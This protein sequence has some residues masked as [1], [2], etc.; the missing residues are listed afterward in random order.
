[1]HLSRAAQVQGE[2]FTR[3][4]RQY[5]ANVIENIASINATQ[6]ETVIVADGNTVIEAVRAAQSLKQKGQKVHVVSQEWAISSLRDMKPL[7]CEHFSLRT[8]LTTDRNERYSTE[9]QAKTNEFLG[10]PAS[11]VGRSVWDPLENS[12]AND[13]CKQMIVKAIP[14]WMVM[15]FTYNASLV[16]LPNHKLAND[17]RKLA[18]KRKLLVPDIRDGDIRAL[19]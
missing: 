15:R 14:K 19:V 10:L 11:F 17:L 16:D 4:M 6:V 2:I 9:L 18:Q 5:G 13:E 7:P 3:N 12:E 8:S 1:M